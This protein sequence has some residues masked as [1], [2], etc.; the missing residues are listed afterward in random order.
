MNTAYYTS[1]SCA[2]FAPLYCY[3]NV[4]L[5]YKFTNGTSYRFNYFMIAQIY[6]GSALIPSLMAF[7]LILILNIV[8]Q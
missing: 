3:R 8:Y 7:G 6:I 2:Q 4:P 1:S 5:N